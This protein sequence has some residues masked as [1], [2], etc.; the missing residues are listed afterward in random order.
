MKDKRI[1]I[2][3]A[4]ALG[5]VIAMAFGFWFVRSSATKASVGDSR[6]KSP[7]YRVDNETSVGRASNAPVSP[8]LEVRA[9]LEAVFAG[10]EKAG[11]RRIQKPDEALNEAIASNDRRAITQA[12]SDLIYSGIWSRDQML[13]VLKD[14]LKSKDT[15]L[16]LQVAETLYTIGDQSGRA[17][18]VK[19]LQLTDAITETSPAYASGNYDFR[20]KAA[21]IVAKFRDY[22]AAQ[23]VLMLYRQTNN[24]ALLDDLVKI[25]S[26][27]A[28]QLLKAASGNQTSSE[29]MELYGLSKASGEASLFGGVQR[30]ESLDMATRLA[31]AW[32]NAHVSSDKGSARFVRDFVESQIAR[33]TVDLPLARKAVQYLGT[34]NDAASISL[35]ERI[36]KESGNTDLARVA[37]ANLI[38][39]HSSQSDVGAELV[40]AELTGKPTKLGIDLAVKLA[41]ASTDPKL[42]KAGQT[43]DARREGE[44]V[45]KQQ[46]A[47]RMQW[48]LWGW[49]DDYVLMLLPK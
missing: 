25:G 7:A 20:V 4:W 47:D 43:F 30:D 36:A 27:E 13:I 22:E 49:A 37:A 2:F 14:A 19:L 15:W 41:V 28:V 48:S 1:V 46:G 32:A 9:G 44:K 38:L 6:N 8:S 17:E 26:P 42:T 3:G 34:L 35:L 21:E 11:A 29:L 12:L 5:V 16:S 24:I 40:I 23:S 31:A 39:N 10:L 33:Q 18:L 45:W